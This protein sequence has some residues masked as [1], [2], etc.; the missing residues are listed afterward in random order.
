MGQF[1][2]K[3]QAKEARGEVVANENMSEA[4]R[5][6]GVAVA[7]GQAG[8][9]DPCTSVATTQTRVRMEVGWR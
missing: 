3:I 8:P 9:W 5:V 7:P 4:V 1:E 6:E 2:K